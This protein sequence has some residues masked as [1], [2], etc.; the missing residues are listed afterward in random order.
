ML[1]NCRGV[2]GVLWGSRVVAGGLW[3]SC[4]ELGVMRA[5]SS[6]MQKR[7]NTSKTKRIQGRQRIIRIPLHSHK[8]NQKQQSQTK[9]T[10]TT[11][12]GIILAPGSC[13]ELRGELPVS[14]RRVVRNCRVAGELRG[15]CGEVV[16]LRTPKRNHKSDDDTEGRQLASPPP[17][18]PGV[19]V[20]LLGSRRGG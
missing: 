3:G 17:P 2:A 19:A 14:G 5:P 6:F 18:H 8:C 9:P 16:G 15:S 20:E 12:I 4:G 11:S 1:G 10:T 7:S 13:G